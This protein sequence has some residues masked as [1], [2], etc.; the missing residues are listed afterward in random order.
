VRK[1][2]ILCRNELTGLIYGVI[3]TLTGEKEKR[4]EKD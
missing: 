1:K 3:L 2:G 4:N